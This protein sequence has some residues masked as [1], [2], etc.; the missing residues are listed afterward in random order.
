[1]TPKERFTSKKLDASHLKVFGCIAYVHVPYKLRKKLDPKAEKYIFIGYSLEQK[2]YHCYNPVTSE[3]RVSKD[4]IFYEMSSWYAFSG[5]ALK[6]DDDHN[7]Y[8]QTEK[9]ITEP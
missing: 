3:F 9:R 6:E 7:S 8:V 5:D 4:V 2:G 1:M